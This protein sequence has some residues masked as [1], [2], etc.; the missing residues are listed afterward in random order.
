MSSDEE[1]RVDQRPNLNCRTVK[2]IAQSPLALAALYR[3]GLG[4]TWEN[5]KQ[6]AEA[7]ARLKV[8]RTHINRAV[9]LTALPEA[10]L[11][12]F[13]SVQILD[14]TA[15]ELL[16]VQ[17]KLGAKQLEQRA[18]VINPEGRSWSE[19]VAMLEGKEP[20]SPA[21]RLHYSGTGPLERAAQFAEGLAANTW[22]TISEAA[23]VTGWNRRDL[24]TAIAISNLPLAVISLFDGKNLSNNVGKTL[25]GIERAIGAEKL[26][27]NARAI[28]DRPKRRTTDE[29]INALAGTGGSSGMSL[30]IR[31]T[32]STLTFEMTFQ[33][34]DAEQL[35]VNAVDVESM[36]RAV[37]RKTPRKKG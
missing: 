15:R 20:V 21:Y 23:E 1:A 36:I 18:A 8:T 26:L 7:L 24:S 35:I 13:S 5:Q 2:S 14:R 17:R 33:V 34:E 16:R 27:R 9:R 31:G 12:L 19:I 3:S 25:I 30:N 28:H 11:S 10:V 4:K 6:A 37:L 29:L 22:S 32:P